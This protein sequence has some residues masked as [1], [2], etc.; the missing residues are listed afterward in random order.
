MALA[1]SARAFAEITELC[2]PVVVKALEHTDV[3]IHDAAS[4]HDVAMAK[5]VQAITLAVQ[6]MLRAPAMHDASELEAVLALA[7][8]CGTVLAQVSQPKPCYAAFKTQFTHVLREVVEAQQANAARGR[9][10]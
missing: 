3:P 4:P 10:N 2:E 5:R 1:V 7:T 6:A 9:P 8:V